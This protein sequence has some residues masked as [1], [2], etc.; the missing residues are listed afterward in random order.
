MPDTQAF[1]PTAQETQ[2]LVINGRMVDVTVPAGTRLLDLL[3]DTLHLT[4]TK[5][6]CGRGECGACTVLIDGRPMASCLALV[7]TTDGAVTTIEGLATAFA[8]LRQAFADHGAFQCGFCTPGQIVRAAAL[9]AEEWP[10]SLVEREAFIRHR[11][12]G[13]IC[14]CTGYTGIVDAIL[15]VAD[16]RALRKSA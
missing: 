2:S 10:A 5:E 6:A 1:A 11:M 12:S 15:A 14:R 8:D 7:D 13:N 3:R 16:A 9:F 4:G